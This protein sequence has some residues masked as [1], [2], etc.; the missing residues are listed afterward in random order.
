MCCLDNFGRRELVAFVPVAILV[1]L[2][3]VEVP[4]AVVRVEVAVHRD[5]MYS[6]SSIPPPIVTNSGLNI[7]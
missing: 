5:N 2:V 4:L 7:T 1:Q 3:A 6:V